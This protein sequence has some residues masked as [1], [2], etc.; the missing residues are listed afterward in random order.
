MTFVLTLHVIQGLLNN[1]FAHLHEN[2]RPFRPTS[3][4]TAVADTYYR[5]Q[6]RG[7]WKVEATT[8]IDECADDRYAT[9]NDQEAYDA[10]WHLAR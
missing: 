10:F 4:F 1:L 2:L 7:Q 8:A 3:M 9:G 6:G 5:P